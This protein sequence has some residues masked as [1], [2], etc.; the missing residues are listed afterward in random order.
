MKTTLARM[1]KSESLSMEENKY[2]AQLGEIEHILNKFEKEVGNNKWILGDLFSAVDI[3]LGVVLHR[4]FQFGILGELL[5]D[6]PGLLSIWT[7]IQSKTSFVKIMNTTPKEDE[8]VKVEEVG[9]LQ[10]EANTVKKDKMYQMS[11]RIS[12]FVIIYIY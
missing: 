12:C 7:G 4:L 3:L 10:L 9:S 8:A 5:N 11:T 6:K 1:K 2:K